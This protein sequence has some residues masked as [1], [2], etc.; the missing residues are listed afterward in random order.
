MRI[1]DTP[2]PA[3]IGPV[4]GHGNDVRASRWSGDARVGRTDAAAAD[5]VRESAG[6]RDGAANEAVNTETRAE[7]VARVRE[8]VASGK[9]VDLAKLADTLLGTGIFFDERA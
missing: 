4:G 6:S 9:P 7:R 1:G 5:A 3:G 2:W 8:L